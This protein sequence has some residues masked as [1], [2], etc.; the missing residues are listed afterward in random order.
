MAFLTDISIHAVQSLL[1]DL[2]AGD[3]I[4]ASNQLDVIT[5]LRNHELY[6]ELEKLTKNLQETLENVED[7]E[8]MLQVKHDLPDVSERLDYVLTSTEQASA[9]TLG[10]SEELIR[11]LGEMATVSDNLNPEQSAMFDQLLNSASDEVTNIMMSQSYQDLTGQVLNRIKI[12]MS[13]FERSLLDLISRSGHDLDKLPQ[14]S[15]EEDHQ[16]ELKGIGPNVTQKAQKDTVNSQV[17]VDDLLSEL[18]I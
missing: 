2:E 3:I 11:L 8:L 10:S 4:S 7:N 1:E 17:D 12:V 5:G 18:G 6:V 15:V 14:R 9:Q 16:E 13:S